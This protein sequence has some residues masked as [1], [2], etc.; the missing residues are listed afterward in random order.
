[1]F[2]PER[3]QK[4]IKACMLTSMHSP[5]DGRIFYKEAKSL[6]KF[7]Y[8]VI[9]IAPSAELVNK[10]TKVDSIRIIPIPRYK[11]TFLT[12]PVT[13]LHLFLQALEV[14]ADVY[15]CHEI[16]TLWVGILLKEVIGTKL[17]YDSHEYHPEKFAERFPSKIRGI[18]KRLT[19]LV[20][21]AFCGKVDYI[22]TVCDELANKFKRWSDNVE[23]V[24]NFALHY[25]NDGSEFSVNPRDLMI[26]GADA[27][28]VYVGSIYKERGIYQIIDAVS[29]LKDR[30]ERI[31]LFFIGPLFPRTLLKQIEIYL[32]DKKLENDILFLGKIPYPQIEG[33]L[34]IADFGVVMDYPEKRNL[35]TV[36]VK[37]FEY[38]Q[39]GLPVVASDLPVTRRVIEKE[40]CGVLSDPLRPDRIADAISTLSQDPEA[41]Q[42]MGRRGREAFLKK[43]NW[44][45][46]ERRLL[47]VYDKITRKEMDV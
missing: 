35:N 20:E 19:Y 8:E 43:Y 16:E 12:R 17:I 42:Q 23:L 24:E 37:V 11:H 3:N 38:M 40:R 7:G 22:I 1:M 9:I 27:I 15:H 30:G 25:S 41:A 44:S 36:A 6:V 14:N 33:Y 10:E 13:L 32:K 21:K 29:I 5:L 45:L 34:A 47:S 39:A 31:K 26:R 4:M 28:G 2:I 46:S 18:F